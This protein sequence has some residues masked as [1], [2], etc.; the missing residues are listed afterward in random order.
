MSTNQTTSAFT[1]ESLP[2][3]EVCSQGC[4]LVPLPVRPME[5]RRGAPSWGRLKLNIW[6]LTEPVPSSVWLTLTLQLGQAVAAAA[7]PEPGPQ[8]Q[9]KARGPLRSFLSVSAAWARTVLYVPQC[10][11]SLERSHFPVSARSSPALRAL[12]LA[13][14]LPY[15]LLCG[16][17][18]PLLQGMH[19]GVALLGHVG[20]P[21]PTF[22]RHRQ[23]FPQLRLFTHWQRMRV[24]YFYLVGNQK[25]RALYSN[26]PQK[27]LL[28]P[29]LNN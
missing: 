23:S 11:W 26:V 6:P 1:T 9:V 3:G 19:L 17:M 27:T 8:P 13:G 29:F 10:P 24:D 25:S 4:P 20:T 5:G 22:L 2:R 28:G 12:P 15:Q 7:L 18:F 16:Q 14:S 21:R